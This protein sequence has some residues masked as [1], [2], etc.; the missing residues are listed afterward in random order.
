MEGNLTKL[1][2]VGQGTYGVV[3]KAQNTQ[4]K[5]ILAVKTIKISTNDD[6]LPS[7]AIREIALLKELRH[8]NIIRLYDVLHSQHCLTLIFEY[9]D[10]DLHRYMESQGFKLTRSEIVTF[11]HEL[12][13]ALEYIHSR[14]I[15]HRDVKPQNLLVNKKKE[16][17][18]ADFGLARSTFIPVG[19]L[20][21]EVVT[22]WY[23]P[24]EILAGIQ[25]Y[26]FAVDIWSAGCVLVEMLLGHPLFPCQTE[27][28][29]IAAI[30][31][32][33]GVN[34]LI[35]LFPQF[36][37]S[38]SITDKLPGKEPVGLDAL[39]GECDSDLVDLARK[40]LDPDPK[41]RISAAE[42]VKHPIFHGL[43]TI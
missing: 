23:R 32:L 31:E 13:L 35:E 4:N 25:D 1:Q 41:T 40:L 26:G 19:S 43:Q 29:M 15:I 22:L 17:K 38:S 24:P 10:W 33:V 30:G 14:H 39:L 27:D 8:K 37:T 34:R 28:E 2:V 3:Y 42:A 18:L 9:C 36:T 21:T 5:E 20:S 12:L 11:I 7:A 16:L 6:G